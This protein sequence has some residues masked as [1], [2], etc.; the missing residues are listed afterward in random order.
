MRLLI[1][2]RLVCSQYRCVNDKGNPALALTLAVQ[3][4]SSDSPVRFPLYFRSPCCPMHSQRYT[5]LHVVPGVSLV[6]NHC[7]LFPPRR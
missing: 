2:V 7:L 5:S 3:H 4:C 6:A 1:V